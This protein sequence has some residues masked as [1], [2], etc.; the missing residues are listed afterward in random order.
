M[1]CS[2][3]AATYARETGGHAVESRKAG[4]AEWVRDRLVVE[5]VEDRLTVS[6]QGIDILRAKES[7]K[8]VVAARLIG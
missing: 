6:Q 8:P 5:P 4:L 1:P 3:I 2:R 7:E